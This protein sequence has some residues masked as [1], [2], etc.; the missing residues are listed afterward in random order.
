MKIK[1]TELIPSVIINHN[2]LQNNYNNY[3]NLQIIMRLQY[4]GRCHVH[5]WLITRCGRTCSRRS[6]EHV[7]PSGQTDQSA[8]KE[9][10]RI[11]SHNI[12]TILERVDASRLNHMMW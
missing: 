12:E 4:T 8:H 2:R 10:H 1:Y 3:R 11:S 6:S 5:V 7:R 9:A